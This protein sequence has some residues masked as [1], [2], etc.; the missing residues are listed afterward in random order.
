MLN[1]LCDELEVKHK[2]STAYHPQTNGLVERYNRTLCETL[3]K[4]ANDNK[5]DWDN[6]V[7][8]ALFA[9]RMKS[10]ETTRHE[11]FYLTYGRNVTLPIEFQSVTLNAMLP[12]SNNV[13]DDLL[14]RVQQI[15]GRMKDDIK[16]RK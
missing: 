2:L 12:N 9:Y 4:F 1:T 5:D 10:H 3:A 13:S 15:T 11:P 16:K 8:S 7:P 6:F 14:Q